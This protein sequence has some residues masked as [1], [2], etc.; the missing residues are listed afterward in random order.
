MDI[1]HRLPG[2]PSSALCLT[3]TKADLPFPRHPEKKRLREEALARRDALSAYAREK[4]AQLVAKT[5]SE[6]DLP[7]HAIISAYW[8][9]R[10]ELDPRPT[11]AWLQKQGL[12]VTLPAILD[13]QTIVF[14]HFEPDCPLVDMGFGTRGPDIDA[15]ELVPDFLLM[16]MAAFDARGHRIGYGAGYYDRAVAKILQNGGKPTLLGI[17]FD[18]QEVEKVPEE[19]HDMR[20]DAIVTESG[21]RRFN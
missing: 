17:A 15:T 4:A 10:S 13:K 12:K 16:P 1:F 19:P 5:L 20:L 2:S 21:L 7:T 3:M 14:R 18:C 6:L 8:P 11:I 9:M